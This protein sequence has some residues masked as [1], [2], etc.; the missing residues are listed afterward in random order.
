KHRQVAMQINRPHRFERQKAVRFEEINPHE[1]KTG[2]SDFS[3][4]EPGQQ[5]S[6]VPNSMVVGR[7]GLAA[8][9]AYCLRRRFAESHSHARRLAPLRR[10]TEV[11]DGDL[12]AAM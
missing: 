4:A 8:E 9:I 7:I 10:R 11:R 3:C 6:F 1:T 12:N 2:I 5:D